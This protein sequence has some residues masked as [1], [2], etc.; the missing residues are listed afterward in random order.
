VPALITPGKSVGSVGGILN[1]S[2]QISGIVAPIVTGF[3]VNGRQSFAAAFGVAAAYLCVGI[4][5]Y[6]LLL[7][8][9]RMIDLPKGDRAVAEG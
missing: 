4:A 7:G 1:L 5:A 9:I 8:E 6:I 3:L 2:N